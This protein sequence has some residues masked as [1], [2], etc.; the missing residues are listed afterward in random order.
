LAN[1]HIRIGET[2]ADISH[3]KL[4]IIR[5]NKSLIIQLFQNLIS[6]AIKFTKKDQHPKISIDCL[7]TEKEFIFSVKD[8]GIGISPESQ[9]KIFEIFQR[10]NSRETYEGTGIGLAICQKISKRLQGRLWVDSE[11]D[12]G[13]TFYFT[14]PKV[15]D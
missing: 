14:V 5:S 6:N 9:E 10:L 11:L 4:P 15:E 12:K 13:A 3:G 2:G 7:E 8:N 1:L